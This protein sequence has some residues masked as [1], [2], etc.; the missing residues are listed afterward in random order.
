MKP[1]ALSSAPTPPIAPAPLDSHTFQTISTTTT[2]PA[3]LSPTNRD[4]S[5]HESAT[6]TNLHPE[7]GPNTTR[8]NR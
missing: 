2:G 5:R 8:A 1:R 3:R 6:Y 4:Q 7:S